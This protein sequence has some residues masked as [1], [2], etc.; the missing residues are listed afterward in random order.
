[1]SGLHLIMS[2]Q[3]DE[4]VVS[5]SVGKVESPLKVLEASKLFGLQ[6]N[7]ASRLLKMIGLMKIWL[8]WKI[9][10]LGKKW[11]RR[12]LMFFNDYVNLQYSRFGGWFEEK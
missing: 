8:G 9:Q 4:V 12:R 2:E 5:I 10:R 11:S 1:M 7:W 6:K 3:S